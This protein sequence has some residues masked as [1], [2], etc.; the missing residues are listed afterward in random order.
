MKNYNPRLA[1]MRQVYPQVQHGLSRKQNPKLARI[2]ITS[3]STERNHVVALTVFAKWLYRGFNRHL[4][5]ASWSDA[6]SYLSQRSKSIRQKTLDLDRNAINMNFHF[7]E[8]LEYVLSQIVTLARNRAYTH[9]QL[10][11][12]ISKASPDLALSIQ[13]AANAGLRSMELI[14]L[15]PPLALRDSERDWHSGRFDGRQQ[16]VPYTVHGKGGLRRE[17][18]VEPGLASLLAAHLRPIPTVVSHRGANLKSFFDIV[19]GH[20]FSLQFGR[21]STREL[22]FSFG[23]HGLRYCFAQ[24]RLLDLICAGHTPEESLKIL[25]QELGHFAV[26]NTLTYLFQRFEVDGCLVQSA[27]IAPSPVV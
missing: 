10:K 16:D 12:L 23:A 20:A 21:L 13:L 4:K 17:V 14:T 18:R 11:F 6:A 27:A 22:G 26:S 5:N 8:K 7:P 2:K 24:R 1:A 9:K 15:A 19:G 3:I 25:A